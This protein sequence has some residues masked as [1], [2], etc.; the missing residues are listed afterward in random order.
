MVEISPRGL[1]PATSL[2]RTHSFANWA[3]NA[4]L[5]INSFKHIYSEIKRKKNK[6]AEA[7]KYPALSIL[8]HFFS[9]C[10]SL[11]Q[12]RSLTSLLFSVAGDGGRRLRHRRLRRLQPK[13]NKLFLPNPLSFLHWFRIRYLKFGKAHPNG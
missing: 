13:K 8:I 12:T 6:G 10:F 4:L 11:S 1:E 2:S 3:R 7:Y 5:L 9:F